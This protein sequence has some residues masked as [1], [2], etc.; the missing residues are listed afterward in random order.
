MPRYAP[1]P[2]VSLDPRN[3]AEIVQAASQRVYEASNQT[4]NDFSAGN[5]LAALIEGQT[6]AQGEFLF[7]AN[8]L[9]DKIL[10]QWIG[11]FLGGMRRLGTPAVARV[12][13][14]IIPTDE[15]VVIPAASQLSTDPNLSGG[16][17]F[18]FLL[19]Q[20][21]VIPI[22]ETSAFGTVSSQFVGSLYN[23]PANSITLLGAGPINGLTVT[24]PQPAVGGSD[25]ETYEQVQERFFTLIRRRNPVSE[26]DWQNF[27]IDLYGLGT[28]CSVQ[29]NRPTQ[30]AYN[31]LRDYA[32]SNGQVSFFVL[33]PGA[34]ELTDEQLARGQNIINFSVPIETRGH[35]YPFSLSQVQY[36]L[37]VEVNANGP[38][39]GDLRNSALSFRNRLYNAL[40]P[41]VNFPA[42][43][44]PTVGEVDSAF[45]L[46]FDP[47]TR[48]VDPNIVSSVAYNTPEM[49]DQYSATYAQVYNFETVNT[50]LNVDDL[51]VTTLPVPVYYP[52]TQAFTPYSTNKKDQTL[53][54]NL[55]LKQIKLLSPG[56]FSQGDVV[57]Y[58]ENSIPNLR[59]VLENITIQ[60]TFEIDSLIAAGKISGIK[61]YSSWTVG[62]S[63][64]NSVSGSLNPQLVQYDYTSDE[65]KPSGTFP[66]SKRPGAFVWYVAQNFTLE[67]ATNNLTGAQAQSKLGT[68]IVPALL[69][70]GGT[71][72]AGTWVQT[73]QVGSGPNEEID[74]YYFYVDMTK[75]AVTKI[76]YVV[77]SF[78]YDQE[79]LKVSAYFDQL[80]S[81][82]VLKEIAVKNGDEGLPIY[83]YKP[84]FKVGQY[85]EYK[86]DASSASSYYI[87]AQ[88]FTPTSTKVQDLINEGLVFPLTFSV[89]DRVDFETQVN[90][91]T[92]QA[93]ARMFTFFKG[94]QTYF[95]DGTDVRAY[96]ATDN[97]TP[98]FEFFVYLKNGVFVPVEGSSQDTYMNNT[99]YVPFFDPRY[100]LYAEDIV[101]AEDGKNVYRVMKAFVPQTQVT[102]WSGLPVDNTARL[103]EYQGNLLR[104]VRAYSCNEKILSQQGNNISSIKLGSAQITVIPKNSGR[105]ANSGQS[106]TYVW[107]NTDSGLVVPQLSWYTNTTYSKTPPNYGTGTLSL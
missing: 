53:Y 107:E 79:S 41:G 39:G 90:A 72:A 7:W 52:V 44:N 80:V 95:R 9:P 32:R 36:N 68:P 48:Y 2:S 47:T 21:V 77:S 1:L 10:L 58:E 93:P 103:E 4:L 30:Y 63:Y 97:V 34:V 105:S 55:E 11:P 99:S 40:T 26:V 18:V 23:V 88:Y 13:F 64:V 65:Y 60:T 69:E 61:T 12:L 38:F 76:A 28:L 45:N 59:V 84:R 98:L 91:G 78:T 75:G 66:L 31:Y 100:S 51:V 86:A 87:A 96:V 16:E 37:T 56:N 19:D 46:S 102:N 71:Y 67:P 33:G 106:Y 94:E 25:V 54:G 81:E 6:F 27:F 17:S 43:N 29:P 49:L 42:T 62:N 89:S 3:E 83:Y 5:P 22:G 104:I 50:L 73:A 92:I 82:G 20:D 57:V 15:V 14:N 8:Q 70:P 85:L 24:N 101:V 35:L 74:P